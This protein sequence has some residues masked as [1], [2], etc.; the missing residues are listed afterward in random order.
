MKTKCNKIKV[1][2][3]CDVTK[4]SSKLSYS[5]R[6]KSCYKIKGWT[7]PWCYK[8]RVW[9]LSQS[10]ETEVQKK[11]LMLRDYGGNKEM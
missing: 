3:N 1:G 4:L 10:N 9:K 2:I 8:M 7:E 6:D 11:L 5:L